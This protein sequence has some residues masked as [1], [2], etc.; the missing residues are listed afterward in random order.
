[1]ENTSTQIIQ[2][3]G[4]RERERVKPRMMLCAELPSADWTQSTI[5]THFENLSCKYHNSESE[6]HF[7]DSTCHQVN[8][9]LML[10]Y[11]LFNVF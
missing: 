11:L 2:E 7:Q 10:Q 8:I 5:E 4:G 3:E 9:L 6:I 1:M